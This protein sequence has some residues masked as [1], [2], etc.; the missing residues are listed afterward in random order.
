M[1]NLNV[2]ICYPQQNMLLFLILI[3]AAGL[4]THQVHQVQVQGGLLD[5]QGGQH[6]GGGDGDQ[7]GEEEGQHRVA[8][9]RGT[10]LLWPS[11]GTD[12]YP[13]NSGTGGHLA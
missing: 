6:R 10:P 5:T 11:W 1:W 13:A 7:L 3:P 4:A 9:A 2:T 12:R 8:G